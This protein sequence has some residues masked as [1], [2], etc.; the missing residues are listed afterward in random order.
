MRIRAATET[1][2]SRSILRMAA[3]LRGTI[4]IT[5]ASRTSSITRSR[6]VC[7][8]ELFNPVLCDLSL[9]PVGQVFILGE[10]EKRI[11]LRE[12]EDFFDELRAGVA[13]GHKKEA[14]LVLS[15]SNGVAMKA[16]VV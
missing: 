2:A 14:G 7:K 9:P 6:A 8:L 1:V 15:R 16:A 3:I 4:R 10:A 12:R 11:E 13:V 5:A